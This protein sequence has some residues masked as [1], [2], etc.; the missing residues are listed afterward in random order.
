MN[1]TSALKQNWWETCPCI[2]RVFSRRDGIPLQ[3]T[4]SMLDEYQ[5]QGVGAIEIFAPYWGGDQY[6]ALDPYE[7]TIVDP[8]IGTM[9][10]FLKLIEECH[11]R[12]MAVIIFINVGYAA[13][14]NV[15]F[16]KAQDDVRRGIESRETSFFLWSDREDAPP[17][18]TFSTEFGKEPEGQWAFSP[19][20]GKY[21][22]V[23]W[24]GFQ[25]DVALPQYNFASAAWQEECKKILR[26][27]LDTGIDG[28]IIDAPFCYLNC[29]FTLNNQCITDVVRE[30]PNQYL[31]PE[32]GGAAGESLRRWL[33]EAGYNS[34]QDYSILRFSHPV[35]LIGEAIQKEDPSLLE[36]ALSTWRETVIRAGGTTY[37]GTY[38]NTPLTEPQFLLELITIVTTGAI[39]HDDCSLLQLGFSK[40]MREKLACVLK[41][42]A[43]TEALRVNGDRKLIQDQNGWYAFSRFVAGSAQEAVVVLNFTDREQE[44]SVPAEAGRAYRNALTGAPVFCKDHIQGT[45][46]PYGYEI[47]LSE[48]R[49]EKENV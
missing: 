42:C 10:E 34:L 31:Q 1:Q 48:K 29:D 41:L 3:K 4:I 39:L 37:L 14:E 30:Y 26:F 25:N 32:G 47:Y 28:M 22:W 27:W 6:G 8:A 19:R 43:N 15:D 5:A 33:L 12:S 9:E 38:W 13:M 21:Y 20:A 23:K 11:R 40:E 49:N 18:K 36:P 16:L 24:L 46:L 2:S 35:T 45:L 44:F 17:P 7:F